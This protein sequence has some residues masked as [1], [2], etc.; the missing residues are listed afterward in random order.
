VPLFALVWAPRWAFRRMRG[1]PALHVRVLPLLAWLSL[2]AVVAELSLSME[3]FLA[4]FGQR[5]LW[6]MGLTA[7]TGAFAVLSLLSL[8]AALRAPRRGMNRWAFGHSLLVAAVFTLVTAYL[9][10]HGCIGFRSWV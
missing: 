9:A 4:R 7:G 10:W 8:W 3:P 6:S 2:A 1:V 5:T